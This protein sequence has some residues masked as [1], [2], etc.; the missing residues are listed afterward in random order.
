MHAL[1]AKENKKMDLLTN[2][3]DFLKGSSSIMML[4]G[5]LGLELDRFFQPDNV[6]IYHLFMWTFLTQ[7][8]DFIFC[9][10]TLSINKLGINIE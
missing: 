6:F 4:L 3:R 1:E 7:A 5:Y 10:A 9:K 2:T 8:Y